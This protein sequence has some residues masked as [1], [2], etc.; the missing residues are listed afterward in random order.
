MAYHTSDNAKKARDNQTKYE[1]K[2][3]RKRKP[4]SRKKIFLKKD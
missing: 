1:I 3:F 2:I 4:K